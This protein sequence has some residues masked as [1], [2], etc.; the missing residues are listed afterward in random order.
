M[1][2][3]LYSA[4]MSLDGYVADEHGNFD[5]AEPDEEV[6]TFINDL[7][8]SVGTHLLGRKMYEVLVVWDDADAFANASGYL[9]D[10]ADLWRE[11]DKVVYSRKL[12]SVSGARTRLERDFDPQAVQQMKVQADADIAI[13][14]PNLAERAFKAGLVDEC[15]FFVAPAVIGGGTR[16]L[17]NG[18]R[19]GLQLLDERRF[20]NGMVYLRYRTKP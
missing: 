9:K 12:E 4:L 16:G 2:K 14:G 17:P 11:T 18:V 10:F 19:I 3:L 6:H 1:A 13:G 7:E 15:H 8:R 5:W 20:E